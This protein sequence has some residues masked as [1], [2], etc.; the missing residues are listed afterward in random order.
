M[1]QSG[2]PVFVF[3][4]STLIM[5][6]V[7]TDRL[8]ISCLEAVMQK[9]ARSFRPCCLVRMP[10]VASVKEDLKSSDVVI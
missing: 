5:A 4:P 9:H 8:A 7:L 6:W 1:T 3:L 10:C 2:D